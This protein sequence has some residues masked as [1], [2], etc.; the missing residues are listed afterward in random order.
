MRNLTAAGLAAAFGLAAASTTRASAEARSFAIT[1]TTVYSLGAEG[2]IEHGTVVIRE[3]KIAAVGA[4]IPVP[5]DAERIDGTGKVVTPGL[6]DAVSHFGIEE[7]S[8]VRE[9][10]DDSVKGKHFTA[11]F[12]VTTAINPRSMLIP[13][14]RIAGLTNA[15]VAPEVVHEGT[16]IAGRG[17]II[18]LGSV[19][20]FVLKNPVAMFVTLGETG[21]DL[22]G[23]SRAAALL[24]F[25]EALE[26]ARDY[27][28][29]RAAYD[30]NR[31]RPYLLDRMDL[32]ALE[33]VL[34]GEIPVVISVDRASD[35]ESAIGL[36]REF[37]FRLVV[38]GG[39]EAWM[40]AGD[41]AKAGAAV[42]LN[43]LDDLPSAFESLGSTLENAARLDRAGVLIAFKTGDSHNARTLTQLAGNAVANGLPYERALKSITLNPA[44]IYGIADR[45]GSLEPG[46]DADL[47]VWSGDP[48]EVT[49][50]AEH[51]FIQGRKIPMVSR[52]T[53]LRDRYLD[54]LKGNHELPPQYA[55]PR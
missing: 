44:K 55:R 3:G 12:D 53:L 54:Y 32:D 24:Y 33:A 48:L 52:Q 9:T 11:S 41:L 4:G 6:F 35:I 7:V 34:K 49:S 45:L 31:R 1:N 16:I 27:L 29:N 5:A 19:D 13:I 30:S 47:V 42:I 26:D 50:A 25:R 37:R 46:R 8:A 36:S 23:G 43:P 51:V 18:T 2:K 20:H 15:V 10:R 17:A 22:A 21:A 28:A 14:N 39:A 38:S 40:A